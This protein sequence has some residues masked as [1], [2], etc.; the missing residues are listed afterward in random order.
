MRIWRCIPG[1]VEIQRPFFTVPPKRVCGHNSCGFSPTLSQTPSPPR[2]ISVDTSELVDTIPTAARPSAV[3]FSHFRGHVGDLFDLHAAG[4]YRLS[5]AM[6]H[7]PDA[8]QDVVQECFLRLLAHI[9]AGGAL[10]NAR[11][12]LYTVAAHACRDRQRRMRRW[13]PW[14]AER[15]TRRATDPPDRGDGPL[16]VLDAIR[17]LAPRDR[18]II[19][20][21]A[22]GLS[23]LE[24]ADAARIRHP[25]VG[26]LLTRALDRLQRQL[27]RRA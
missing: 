1:A 22:Q 15:D 11:G 13:L 12:W 8:A 24:I 20:L 3:Q 4:L 26:R 10:P 25:S 18:L 27:D 2:C 14:T 19:A 7:D 5:L 21:R 23:Y 9:E 17:A 6:L 16:A